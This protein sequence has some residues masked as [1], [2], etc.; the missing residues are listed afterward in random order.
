MAGPTGRQLAGRRG[1]ELAC[2]FL[3]AQGFTILGRNV[4]VGRDE[5][6]IVAREGRVL[7]FVEV[8]L[9]GGRRGRLPEET[10]DR[11]KCERMLRAAA[12]YLARH[13]LGDQPCRFDLVALRRRRDGACELRHYRGVFVDDSR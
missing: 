6:D 10:L 3:R 8:R 4:R 9:R 13:G 5:I 1:E 12:G 11:S 7:V 2:R